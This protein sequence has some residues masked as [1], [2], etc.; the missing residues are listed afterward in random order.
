MSTDAVEGHEYAGTT[1]ADRYAVHRTLTRG[2]RCVLLEARHTTTRARV[3][4]KVLPAGSTAQ[5]E[6]RLMREARA[7]GAITH[8]SVARILDAGETSR[9]PFLALEL[10]HGRSLDAVLLARPR[11]SLSTTMALA[12]QLSGALDTAHAAGVIH[13]DLKPS[14]VIVAMGGRGFAE[15]ATLVDFGLASLAGELT[16][17]AVPTSEIIE[18]EEAWGDHEPSP[19]TDVRL[20]AGLVVECLTGERVAPIEA[21]RDALLTR[22]A[23][24]VPEALGAVLRVALSRRPEARFESAAALARALVAASGLAPADLRLGLLGGESPTG[25]ARQSPRAPFV[26]PVRVMVPNGPHVDGRTIDIS[27]SGLSLMFARGEPP[28][29]AVVV[30]FC[31]PISARLTT[32][33]AEVRW[34]RDRAGMHVAG[35]EFGQGERAALD[36]IRHYVALMASRA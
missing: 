6:A 35:L 32:I 34:W 8:P 14:N 11:L 18:G 17:A 7:L 30:R 13:R 2:E 25:R 24:E 10:V 31:L 15:R 29:G 27:E 21:E 19:R 12:G 20:L 22:H 3:A 28:H 5:A 33:P 1:V 4:L 16:D 9:G 36:D 26:A 23:A